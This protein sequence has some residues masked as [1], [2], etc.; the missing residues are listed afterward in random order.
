MDPPPVD[1]T[2]KAETPTLSSWSTYLTD[3]PLLNWSESDLPSHWQ[4]L[5]QRASMIAPVDTDSAP[6][7]YCLAVGALN[8]QKA[9]S[10]YTAM[11]DYAKQKGQHV[12]MYEVYMHVCMGVR[13]CAL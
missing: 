11:L 5:E 7:L 6:A 4:I 3:Y 2:W 1:N 8:N 13:L 10:T 9:A 12:F